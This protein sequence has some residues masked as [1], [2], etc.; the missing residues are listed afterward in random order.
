VEFVSLTAAERGPAL[1]TG[2]IDMLSRNCTWTS[3][4]DSQWGNFTTVMFYDGQGMMVRKDTGF[5]KL[6]DLDGATVCV[7][8]G[9]TTREEP[10]RQLP[11]AGTGFHGSNL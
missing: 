10:V 3:S 6:E 11:S 9:T 5:T 2:E 1:Q 4:R 7:T 8:T